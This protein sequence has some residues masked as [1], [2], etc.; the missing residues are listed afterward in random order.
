M[1]IT[2]GTLRRSK[3][4]K[5]LSELLPERCETIAKDE[6][7]SEIEVA[8]EKLARKGK[9]LL[10]DKEIQLVVES[11]SLHEER[12]DAEENKIIDG[13]VEGYG[14]R[15]QRA[16]ELYERATANLMMKQK[17]YCV[18]G[19]KKAKCKDCGGEKLCEHG[20]KD[21]CKLCGGTAFCSHGRRK[22][23]CKDCGGS[24]C[25]MHGRVKRF[26]RD[27]GGTGLCPHGKRIYTCK[28]CKKLKR[29][30]KKVNDID[31]K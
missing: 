10:V 2:G 23:D 25:C 16:Q 17:G 15:L 21:R 14:A 12:G 19:K 7:E 22:Q 31:A 30:T 28:E 24:R 27:C 9:V 11:F 8:I 13:N 29:A 20:R 1:H 18:H 6:I 5:R 4:R 26:C 3:L